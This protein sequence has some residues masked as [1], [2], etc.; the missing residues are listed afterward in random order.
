MN[1]KRKLEGWKSASVWPLIGSLEFPWVR[2]RGWNRTQH[3][4]L[5]PRLGPK[6]EV[7]SGCK[8]CAS[9]ELTIRRRLSFDTCDLPRRLL[10]GLHLK[11]PP[12]F[13]RLFVSRLAR[14]EVTPLCCNKTS[15]FVA[16]FGGNFWCSIEQDQQGY[17]VVVGQDAS[18]CALMGWR[19][20]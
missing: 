1:E 19:V 18:R 16:S 15:I 7:S 4:W 5:D 9:W 11:S 6:H 14:I 13:L 20:S 8:C 17:G 3:P 12:P 10:T 2:H